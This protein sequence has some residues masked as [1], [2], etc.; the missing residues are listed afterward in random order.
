M[1]DNYSSVTSTVVMHH[2]CKEKTYKIDY[3]IL[4]NDLFQENYKEFHSYQSEEDGCD[5]GSNHSDD[6]LNYRFNP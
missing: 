1:I 4:N 3:S 6:K 5:V 2:V